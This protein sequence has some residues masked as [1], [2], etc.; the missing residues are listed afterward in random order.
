M[1]RP[2]R[3]RARLTTTLASVFTLGG[4][5]GLVHTNPPALGASGSSE[6]G[7][8]AAEDPARSAPSPVPAP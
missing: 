3:M 5:L 4:T 1:T 2:R 6:V 8:P 7:V